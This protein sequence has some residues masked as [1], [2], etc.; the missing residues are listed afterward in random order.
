MVAALD[1]LRELDFLRRCQEV[2][3]ADVFQEELERIC[4]D[5]RPLELERV[6]CLLLGDELDV[7]LLDQAVK[8]VDLTGIELELVEGKRDF[9]GVQP[10]GLFPGMQKLPGFFGREDASSS[11]RLSVP[12]RFVLASPH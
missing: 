6:D 2:D 7:E 11:P 12:Q 3:F 4:R 8:L 9:V 5:V 1:L 10:P